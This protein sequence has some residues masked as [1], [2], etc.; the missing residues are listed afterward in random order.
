M[1][2]SSRIERIAAMLAE[3]PND[4]E[5]RYMLAME[6]VSAGD[7]TA[8]ARCF[9]ELIRLSPT[10]PPGYHQ[11][12]RTLQ[13]L[14]RVAEARAVLERGIP[15]TAL[16]PRTMPP[17]PAGNA[18]ISGVSGGRVM[19]QAVTFNGDQHEVISLRRCRS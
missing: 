14:D 8:A 2:A 17:R 1:S 5:L 16:A 19:E 6:H 18:A 11:A 15:V 3:E 10:Y 7:D 9:E 12:A 13:R 4:P